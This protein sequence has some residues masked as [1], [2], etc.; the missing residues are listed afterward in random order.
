MV[1]E[2]CMHTVLEGAENCTLTFLCYILGEDVVAAERAASLCTACELSAKSLF[3][4]SL[5]DHL[6]GYVIRLV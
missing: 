3:V 2:I 6:Q 4:L 1:L 5:S